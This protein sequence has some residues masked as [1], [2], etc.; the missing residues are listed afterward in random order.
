M[1]AR[2]AVTPPL[3]TRR[4]TEDRTTLEHSSAVHCHLEFAEDMSR[5]F[6]GGHSHR[7][8]Q[9]RDEARDMRRVLLS[10]SAGDDLGAQQ[11]VGGPA[12]HLS[13]II[14]S[15]LPGFHFAARPPEAAGRTSSATASAGARAARCGELPA[16]VA[17]QAQAPTDE[18]GS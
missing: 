8:A 18:G 7:L 13:F 14:C 2:R 1:L 16:C 5:P 9:P 3:P 12:G 10:Q 6:P 4:G 11:R 17:P 15:R